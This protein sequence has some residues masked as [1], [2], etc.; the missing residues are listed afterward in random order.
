[1][2][3]ERYEREHNVPMEE[4]AAALAQMV[5]GKTPLLLKAPPERLRWDAPGGRERGH[6][7]EPHRAGPERSPAGRT[8]HRDDAPHRHPRESGDPAIFTQPDRKQLDSRFR[9]NDEQGHTH[10]RGQHRT[11]NRP[12]QRPAHRAH[13]TNAPRP[14]ANAAEAMFF[15][16]DAP[17]ARHERTPRP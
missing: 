1:E 12:E 9:G 7:R 16:D 6:D 4:I 14:P 5:Q 15:D 13:E 3:V 2:L 8:R 17:P 11:E 10:G